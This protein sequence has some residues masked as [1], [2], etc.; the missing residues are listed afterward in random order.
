[1][2]VAVIVGDEALRRRVAEAFDRAPAHWQVAL[3]DSPPPGADVIVSTDPRADVVVDPARLNGLIPAIEAHVAPTSTPRLVGVVG[4]T[5]GCG[6]TTVALYLC[7]ALAERCEA[8]YLETDPARRSVVA[9]LGMSGDA[10]CWGPQDAGGA[11]FPGLPVAGVRIFPAPSGGGSGSDLGSRLGRFDIVVQEPQLP[12]NGLTAGVLVV[13]PTMAGARRAAE[14]SAELP[15]VAWAV[16]INRT[17]PGEALN[18]R[19]IAEITGMQPTMHLPFSPSVR[20][21]EL[22]GRL[23]SRWTRFARSIDRLAQTI[24]GLP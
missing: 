18:G 1:M 6:V 22:H 9:R 13:P 24:G 17:A 23:A 7:R 10:R 12:A 4:A 19:R 16:L 3:F 2:R 14:M 15:D 20:R 11:T 8:A 21:A 5:G